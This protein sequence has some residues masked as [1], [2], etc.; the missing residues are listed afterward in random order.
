MG[1][2]CISFKQQARE[3]WS[4]STTGYWTDAAAGVF[5]GT[6]QPGARRLEHNT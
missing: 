5:T 2:I 4:K 3:K 1:G 6:I